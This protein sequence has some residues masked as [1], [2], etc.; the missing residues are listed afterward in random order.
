MHLQH[1]NTTASMNK[2]RFA[3]KSYQYWS[4]DS[5]VLKLFFFAQASTVE[6]WPSTPNLQTSYPKSSWSYLAVCQSQLQEIRTIWHIINH[7]SI[8]ILR[9][10]TV[11]SQWT[12]L[13]MQKNF[14]A[15]SC[16]SESVYIHSIQQWWNQLPLAFEQLK[17]WETQ[18]DRQNDEDYST[19]CC[20][21]MRL[22]HS[23]D[24]KRQASPR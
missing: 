3:A 23:C 24:N 20:R 11:I 1:I 10:R 14:I 2:C 21:C 5:A 12:K 19:A 17:S 4:F 6:M 18:A 9:E 16:L 13:T 7:I 15:K 8:K 22:Q